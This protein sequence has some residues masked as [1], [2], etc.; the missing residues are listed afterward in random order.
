VRRRIRNILVVVSLI[1][2]GCAVSI[3]I[4]SYFRHITFF[5]PARAGY[6]ELGAYGYRGTVG[7][8]AIENSRAD[9]GFI[10]GLRPE[11]DAARIA[12]DMQMSHDTV[13]GLGLHRSTIAFRGPPV[14]PHRRWQLWVPM[15]FLIGLAIVPLL[16]ARRLT[17]TMQWQAGARCA[18][19]G[20]DLRATPDRCPE[21]GT[22]VSTK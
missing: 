15:W 11:S 21:C 5:L 12:W 8:T 22:E 14:V 20:Y 13:M 7:F 17:R 1:Y 19:C 10:L 16:V 4:V 2:V 18:H 9:H 3:W 6:S